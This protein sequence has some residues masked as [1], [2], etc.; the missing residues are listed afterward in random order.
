MTRVP[1]MSWAVQGAVFAFVAIAYIHEGGPVH[2]AALFSLASALGFATAA[3][4][5]PRRRRIP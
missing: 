2:L 5:L 1:A 3:L 4:A